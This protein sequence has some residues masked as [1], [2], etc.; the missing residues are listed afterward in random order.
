MSLDFRGA[1]NGT[2]R[3]LECRRW[4]RQARRGLSLM[5]VMFA[6]GVVMI[7]LLGIAVLVPI[8]GR[9]ARDGSNY[10]RAARAGLNAVREFHMRE[11]GRPA[12]WL[13][14]DYTAVGAPANNDTAY[15]LDPRFVAVNNQ[16]NMPVADSRRFFPYSALAA[17]PR[18]RRISL[19]RWPASFGNSSLMSTA[20]AD[21]IFVA[22]DDLMIDTPVDPQLPAQQ[23]FYNQNPASPDKRQ[24]VGEFSWMA[25]LSPR[26]DGWTSASGSQQVSY[27]LSIVVFQGRDNAMLLDG[28]SERW[29]VIPFT[30]AGAT[31]T[32]NGFF[33]GGVSGG[34]VALVDKGMFYQI[35]GQAPPAPA[36]QDLVVKRG[37]WILLARSSAVGPIYKWYKITEADPDETGGAT[38]AELLGSAPPPGFPIRHVT[39][40][41]Q[42]W[43]F[44]AN[45]QTF[46]YILP[47]VVSVYE[48]TIR[49]ENSSLWS[50]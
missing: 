6:I 5:E 8:A 15:C 41:G 34:D 19:R 22:L 18:M 14:P 12:N 1:N 23:V 36:P 31:I 42:D 24:A 21:E 26:N 30:M 28:V 44:D 27:T 35:N 9:A 10:D 29:A 4:R 37:Q 48:K 2:G 3:S 25:T 38:S 7:G 33:G 49:L 40:F 11:M 47:G 39:L 13:Y 50:Q 46:A 17:M 43:T 16:V 20:L 45:N 32:S